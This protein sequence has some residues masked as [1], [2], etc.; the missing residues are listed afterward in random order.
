MDWSEFDIPSPIA[1]QA[2]DCSVPQG[3]ALCTHGLGS[4]IGMALGWL[5]P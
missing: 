2:S 3:L 1:H 5:G 4:L